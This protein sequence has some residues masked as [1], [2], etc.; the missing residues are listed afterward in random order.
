MDNITLGRRIRHFRNQRGMTQLDLELEIE[1]S[2]GSLS[3]IE[4]GKISPLKE[5][6]DKIIKTLN[7]RGREREYLCG[8]LFYPAS[9]EEIQS[10]VDEVSEYFNKKGVLAYLVDDRSRLCLLSK[11]FKKAIE[12]N[13]IDSA[14]VIG[15]PIIGLAINKDYGV[16]QFYETK[17]YNFLLW[18]AM[19]RF[20]STSAFMFDDPSTIEVYEA[21]KSD[22]LATKIW[23]DVNSPSTSNF[24]KLDNRKVS[25]NYKGKTFDMEYAANSVFNNYRFDVIEYRPTN[26]V[27]KVVSKLFQ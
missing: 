17:N 8:E 18:A 15:K 21:I 24:H 22:P 23:E 16:R 2:P 7:I 26:S 12:A 10:A 14:K 9:Q 6:L 5:T 3:R 4:N 1:L 19:N 20:K 13:G 27:L 25:V 11:S